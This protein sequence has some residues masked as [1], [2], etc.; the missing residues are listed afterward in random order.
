MW[1]QLVP[2]TAICGSPGTDCV[3][4]DLQCA[5]GVRVTGLRVCSDAALTAVLRALDAVAQRPETFLLPGAG[6]GVYCSYAALHREVTATTMAAVD[7]TQPALP[8]LDFHA[9]DGVHGSSTFAVVIDGTKRPL[10]ALA[11]REARVHTAAARHHLGC[12]AT[13]DPQQQ[14][15]HQVVAA[16]DFVLDPYV[17]PG[18]RFLIMRR[19]TPPPTDDNDEETAIDPDDDEHIWPL[20][21][22]V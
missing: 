21:V 4:K 18:L 9:P 20:V 8:C 7:T 10:L 6:P 11:A 16:C 19:M 14:Q 1:R 22:V 17:P 3:P 5:D 15:Q 13:S 2:G 12:T